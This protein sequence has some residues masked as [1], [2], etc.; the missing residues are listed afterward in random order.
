MRRKLAPGNFEVI[1]SRLEI[2]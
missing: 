2:P 1:A